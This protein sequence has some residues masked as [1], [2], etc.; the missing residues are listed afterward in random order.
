MFEAR[1]H[2]LPRVESRLDARVEWRADARAA[3]A[4]RSGLAVRDGRVV[5]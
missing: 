5:A 3:R 2:L 4:A 1:D